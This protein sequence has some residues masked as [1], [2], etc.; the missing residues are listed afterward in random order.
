MGKF[1]LPEAILK[2]LETRVNATIDHARQPLKVKEYSL[3]EGYAWISV[4]VAD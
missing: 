4:E 2:L 1:T 3:R